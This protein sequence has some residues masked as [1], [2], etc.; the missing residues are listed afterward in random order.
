M[1]QKNKQLRSCEPSTIDWSLENA[2]RTR[3]T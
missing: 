3:E 1:M 2:L